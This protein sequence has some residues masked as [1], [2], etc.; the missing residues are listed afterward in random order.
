MATVE[1]ERGLAEAHALYDRYVKPLEADHWGE[2]VAVTPDGRVFLGESKRGVL[3]R[4]VEAVGRGSGSYVF[5]VGP[6]VVG[7]WR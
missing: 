6:L 2:F 7:R 5:K 1:Q 4:L 3:D